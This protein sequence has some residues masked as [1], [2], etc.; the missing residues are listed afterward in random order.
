MKRA[1]FLRLLGL[2]PFAAVA[3][4]RKP[5]RP[6]WER[7]LFSELKPGDLFNGSQ[8]GPYWVMLGNHSTAMLSHQYH[9]A[10]KKKVEYSYQTINQKQYIELRGDWYVW[11]YNGWRMDQMR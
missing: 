4:V 9:D 8:N 1:G 10:Y 7:V 5:Q 2:L 3:A 6:L 11:R